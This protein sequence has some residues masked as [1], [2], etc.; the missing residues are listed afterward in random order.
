MQGAAVIAFDGWRAF[1][2][3]ARRT[4]RTPAARASAASSW[5]RVSAGCVAAARIP[6]S[7]WLTESM[8]DGLAL[9]GASGYEPEG[10]V[11]F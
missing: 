10:D 9:L 2:Y 5:P 7:P 3:H 8:T 6:S 1:I 4:Q 11:A